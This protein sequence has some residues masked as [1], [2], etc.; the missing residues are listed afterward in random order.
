[1]KKQ[2]FPV[3]IAALAVFL[4][5][6]ASAATK[7]VTTTP[8]LASLAREVGGNFVQVESLASFNEDPH[9]VDGRPSF[10]LKLRRADLLVHNGLE[11]EIGWLPPLLLNARNGDIQPGKPGNLDASRYAGPL[12]GIPSGPVDRR[13][14]DIHPG[15]NPHFIY[16]PDYGLRIASAIAERLAQIDAEHAGNYQ[17]N[18]ALFREKLATFSAGAL[19]RMSAYRGKEVVCYHDSLRYLTYWLGLVE[20]GYIEPL[21]GVSPS[22]SH[23]AGLI[24]AMRERKTALVITEPWH[25]LKTA[26]IVAAKADIP[27]VVIPG[28]VGAAGS[29]TYIEFLER[30]VQALETGFSRKNSN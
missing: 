29:A 26:E 12:L 30:L 9:Y 7:I 6:G 13:M 15:G 4:P 8:G 27:V 16:N 17:A 10:I 28:D 1:M 19:K 18:L 21:P 24:S 5:G 22:P 23:V 14:G 25:D 11:L 3:L 2:M 20:S